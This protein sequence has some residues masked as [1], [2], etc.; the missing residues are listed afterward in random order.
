M[1]NLYSATEIAKMKLKGL[2]NTRANIS[3]R[4]QKEGWY[5]EERTGLGGGRRVYEIPAHYLGEEKTEEV[6][7]AEITDNKQRFTKKM[8]SCREISEM[9]LPGMPKSKPAILAK[10]RRECWPS[11]KRTWIGGTFEVYKIPAHYL[12]IDNEKETLEIEIS[13][14]KQCVANKMFSAREIGKMNLP[15]M[16]KSKPG[17]MAKARRECWPSETRTGFGGTSEVYKIP[18]Y[19]LDGTEAKEAG[20][21]INRQETAKPAVARAVAGGQQ[22]NLA[23]LQQVDTILEE[24]LQEKEV[25]LLPQRRGTVLAFLYDCVTKGVD[26]ERLKAALQVLV[27]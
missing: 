27:A 1:K 13:D 20:Q 14:N 6:S 18:A 21:P 7:N 2:P 15:G 22:A 4:A 5:C 24:V 19:Y 16:P 10:A 25:K 9:N 8:Y 23:L 17:I 11:E 12:D 26:L 3:I